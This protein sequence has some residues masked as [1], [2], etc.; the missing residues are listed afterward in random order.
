MIE[1]LEKLDKYAAVGVLARAAL[2]LESDGN[3]A[4]ELRIEGEE[5]LRSALWQ[6]ARGEVGVGLDDNRPEVIERLGKWLDDLSEQ[7]IG[8]PD[9]R[10]ALV[11]LA[12]RGDLPSDLYQVEIVQNVL[13]IYG[14]QATL[15]RKLIEDT[16]RSPDLE[17]HY[18]LP[19]E[20]NE[21]ALISLF[22]RAFRT[23]WPVKDFSLLVSAQRGEG[24]LLHVNQAWRVYPFIVN[25]RGVGS[26]LVKTLE[27]FANVYGAD[28]DYGGRK[29]H[30]FVLVNE[31]IPSGFSIRVEGKKPIRANVSG[32]EQVDSITEQ[33]RASLVVSIDLDRYRADLKRMAVRDD[34]ITP[35]RTISRLNT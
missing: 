17:Q 21:P 7:I 27:Q 5:R 18:G 3:P 28:I 10:S 25:I 15:N 34:Q 20:P 35:S 16:I 32:F 14:A 31:P 22:Y 6:E 1:A 8:P 33:E 29:G 30:F 9:T 19:G 12:E 11:R 23:P 26:D 13:D 4:A 2:A 24:L